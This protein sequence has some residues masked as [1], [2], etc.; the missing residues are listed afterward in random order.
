MGFH[1]SKLT[2]SEIANVQER[3]LVTLTGEQRKIRLRRALSRSPKWKEIEGQLDNAIT[4]YKNGKLETE[5][6]KFT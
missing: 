4:M 6:T 3:G 5:K 2:E 1:Y